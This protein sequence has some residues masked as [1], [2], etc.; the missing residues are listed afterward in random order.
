MIR[1]IKV[2]KLQCNFE[3]TLQWSNISKLIE[4]IEWSYSYSLIYQLYKYVP[5]KDVPEIFQV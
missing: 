3:T 4:F 2:A 1:H 5:K